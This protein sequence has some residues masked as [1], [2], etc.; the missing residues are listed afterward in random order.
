LKIVCFSCRFILNSCFT[1]ASEKADQQVEPEYHNP[2]TDTAVPSAEPVVEACQFES[3][4]TAS[5]QN[6][7][8]VEE[9][10]LP[11]QGRYRASSLTSRFV[12]LDTDRQHV[13]LWALIVATLYLLFVLLAS[14]LI[15]S[16][17]ALPLPIA[18]F[19]F[20]KKRQPEFLHSIVVLSRLPLLSSRFYLEERAVPLQ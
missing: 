10:S 15:P 9:F 11:T 18:W 12:P 14:N 4:V 6:T 1:R 8:H 19:A 3:P 5:I 20:L 7:S 2:P 17:L 13:S 16:I